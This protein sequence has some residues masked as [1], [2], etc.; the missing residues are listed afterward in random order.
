MKI[1]SRGPDGGKT[2]VF[3]EELAEIRL[4]AVR[5][6]SRVRVK[7]VRCPSTILEF[8]PGSGR[9]LAACF[10]HASRTE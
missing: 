8:D 10:K 6:T 2:K 7:K 3:Q 1:I 4:L 9:T 5:L